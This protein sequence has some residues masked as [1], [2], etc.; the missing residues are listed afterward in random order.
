MGSGSLIILFFHKK[1]YKILTSK[2]L[3]IF[4]PGTKQN[5]EE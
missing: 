1:K 2:P 5:P 4:E 3:V